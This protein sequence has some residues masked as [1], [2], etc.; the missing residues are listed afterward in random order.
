MADISKIDGTAVA[1]VAKVMGYTKAAGDNVMGI[2]FP[3]AG[4]AGLTVDS[5]QGV[6]GEFKP[7]LVTT[8]TNTQNNVQGVF[9]EFTYVIDN[10][11]A[12]T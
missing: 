9:G 7:A 1:N 4:G 2:L 10:S 8:V 11:N 6:F 12:D 5:V 3:S